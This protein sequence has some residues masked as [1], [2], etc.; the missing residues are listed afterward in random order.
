MNYPASRGGSGWLLGR[1]VL[2]GVAEA[3]VLVL[4]SI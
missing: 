3:V 1:D 2:F 4:G